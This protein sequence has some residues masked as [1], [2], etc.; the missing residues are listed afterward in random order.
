M[1]NFAAGTLRYE[2]ALD[3]VFLG[4]LGRFSLGVG[5]FGYELGGEMFLKFGITYPLL[6][7]LALLVQVNF[8]YR[9]CDSLGHA[10]GVDPVYSGR[11]EL[12]LSPG[13]HYHVT[14]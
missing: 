9:D 8:Y 13:L 14:V 3:P 5:K 7:K 6:R 2:M 10:P 1:Q 4:V 11:E 12:F